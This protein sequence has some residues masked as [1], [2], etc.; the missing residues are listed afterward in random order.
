MMLDYEI[1]RWGTYLLMFA[2]LIFFIRKGNEIPALYSFFFFSSGLQRFEVTAVDKTSN[3]VYVAGWDIFLMTDEN[4]LFALNLFFLGYAVFSLTFFA[5]FDDKPKKLREAD[6]NE[7]LERYIQNHLVLI[8]TL[9]FICVIL[10][11]FRG[12]IYEISFSYGFFAQLCAA[13]AVIMLIFCG[14]NLR[15]GKLFLLR[16]LFLALGLFMGQYSNNAYVRFSFLSWITCVGVMF[17]GPYKM[18][19][20]VLIYTV[21]GIAAF[22]IFS[23]AGVSRRTNIKDLSTQEIVELAL[24]RGKASEDANMLDGFMMVT[25]V[26]PAIAP[27]QYGLG[28]LEILVRPIPRSWWPDKPVGGWANKIGINEEYA[29]QNQYIGISESIFGTFYSEGG[30]IALVL[31]SISYVFVYNYFFRGANQYQSGMKY[32]MKGLI[33][34]ATVPLLRGG[35]IPG[36]VAFWGMS[37]WPLYFFTRSYNKF[38]KLEAHRQKVLRKR[39]EEDLALKQVVIKAKKLATV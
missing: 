17:T 6:S 14:L 12:Y 16:V 9:I 28:H 25:Q 30:V 1:I 37:F 2:S 32:L 15:S 4:A 22:V 21:G 20:K 11:L 3:F 10:L 38:L 34:A 31:F 23:I 5:F 19:Y 24:V 13:G 8:F 36:I 39:Y 29:A 27:F 7:V 18:G 33:I 35:D 26:Y